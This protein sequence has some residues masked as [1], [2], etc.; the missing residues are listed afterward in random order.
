LPA[1]VVDREQAQ[2]LA[3]ARDLSGR[4][5]RRSE[6]P[7]S[8]SLRLALSLMHHIVELIETTPDCKLGR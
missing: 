3:D 8:D 6:Q 2:L 4:L 1:L 7:P 5:E